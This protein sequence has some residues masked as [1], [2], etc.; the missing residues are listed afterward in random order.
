MS[1]FNIIDTINEVISIQQMK[2]D[3]QGILLEMNMENIGYEKGMHN[4]II[5]HDENRIK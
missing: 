5:L 1:N 4:P 3:S 2:A